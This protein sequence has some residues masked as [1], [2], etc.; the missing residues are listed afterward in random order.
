MEVKCWIPFVSS[1]MYLDCEEYIADSLFI[2]HEL[3]WVW[4]NKHE[5]K[6]PGSPFSFIHCRVLSRDRELFEET[7]E[8]LQ[9]KLAFAGYDMEEYEELCGICELAGEF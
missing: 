2:D 4:F 3:T 1:F 6:R 7:M 5:L 9:R 8:H